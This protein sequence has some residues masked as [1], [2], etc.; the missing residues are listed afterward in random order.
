VSIRAKLYAAIAL[1]V[2]GPVVTIAL[3]PH[4]QSQLNRFDE[5]RDRARHVSS[6]SV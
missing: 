2:L 3:A 1:T 5:V 6:S 4:G